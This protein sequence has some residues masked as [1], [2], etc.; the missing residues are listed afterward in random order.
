MTG[1]TETQPNKKYQESNITRSVAP[2]PSLDIVS[3]NT[4]PDAKHTHRLQNL[5]DIYHINNM[6]EHVRIR[7]EGEPMR[8]YG[9]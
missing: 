9:L 2:A 6:A 7:G 1:S 3:Q 4:S 8:S 5:R